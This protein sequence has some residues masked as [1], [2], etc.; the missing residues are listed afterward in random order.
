[1]D[2]RRSFAVLAPQSAQPTIDLGDLSLRESGVAQAPG[3]F[4]R[5]RGVLTALVALVLAFG[6]APSA[7]GRAF[8]G[9]PLWT[10]RASLA[11]FALGA[12]TVVVSEPG[13]RSI[14]GRDLLTGIP[15]WRIPVSAPPQVTWEPSD[16]IAAVVVPDQEV[17]DERG[18]IDE[19]RV[20][21]ERPVINVVDSIV[22]L[23]ITYGGTIVA[24]VPG[25]SYLLLVMGG[26]VLV[27]TDRTSDPLS[28]APDRDDCIEVS[29]YDTTTGRQAWRRP[30][31]GNV[32]PNASGPRTGVSRLAM[33]GPDGL[34]ELRDPA[35]GDRLSTYP[36][37]LRGGG[38]RREFLLIDDTLFTAV[39]TEDQAVLTAH[40]VGPDGHEWTTSIG[41]SRD[42]DPDKARFYLGACGRLLCLHADGAD[43]AFDPDTGAR[44]VRV[45]H[46]I[47]GEA[48]NTIV[49]VPST[50]VPGSDQDRRVVYL[51][52]GTDGGLIATLTDTAPVPWRDGGSRVMLAHQGHG[53]TD[54]TVL[55]ASGGSRLLGTVSGTELTCGASRDVLVCAD[56]VGLIRA[57]RMP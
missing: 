50:E 37:D 51:F 20:T 45:E 44:R 39:R 27:G 16:E 4:G 52:A 40:P 23:M 24:N 35:T 18:V 34:V 56:P 12:T 3:T 5:R 29:A 49:A 6:M 11:G 43:N 42:I 28:C 7:A 19:H 30:L 53:T 36:L 55:D 1:V 8:L 14:V 21:N 47:V 41:V 10:M 32:V 17:T 38:Q 25:D 54:V 33:I 46:Q 48:G 2:A 13:A 22:T 31:T 26:Y 15:R 9:E 57:W